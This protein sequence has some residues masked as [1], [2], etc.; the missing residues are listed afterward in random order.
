MTSYQVLAAPGI[1]RFLFSGSGVPNIS[2]ARYP[3]SPAAGRPRGRPGWYF[4]CTSTHIVRSS[5]ATLVCNSQASCATV[6]PLPVIRVRVV[7]EPRR[8][9]SKEHCPE[10]AACVPRRAGPAKASLVQAQP[11]PASPPAAAPS[12]RGAGR[13]ASKKKKQKK[14]PA[15]KPTVMNVAKERVKFYAARELAKKVGGYSVS[16]PAHLCTY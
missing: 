5:M 2:P 14:V 15:K 13:A 12:G 7:S 8:D 6:G 4:F 10:V 11:A 9:F 16:P 3:V 1:V